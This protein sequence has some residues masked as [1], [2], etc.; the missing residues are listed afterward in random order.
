MRQNLQ[1]ARRA[2]R[3]VR[4]AGRGLSGVR[5]DRARAGSRSRTTS[6]RRPTG[7]CRGSRSLDGRGACW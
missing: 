6:S 1:H 7:C 5:L 2:R 3:P 4:G